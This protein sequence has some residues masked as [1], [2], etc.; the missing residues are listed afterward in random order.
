[1]RG[2][3]VVVLAVAATS[4]TSA[5]HAGPDKIAFPQ[6]FGTLYATVDRP[7]IK[8]YR[9]LY[10]SDAA[11]K[12]A[13]EGRPVPSG[14]VITMVQYRAQLDPQ[15][16]PIKDAN[17]RFVKGEVA[18][19]ALME[20]RT[21]WGGEYPPEL[22]NGEWEYAAF[23]PDKQFNQKANYKGCF[24][25]HKPHEKLDYV[26][27]LAK[28][29]GTFPTAAAQRKTGATDVNIAS[30]AFGPGKIAVQPGQA[31]SWTNTDD[32][33]HQIAVQGRK[34]GVLLKG[35]SEALKFDQ[36]GLFDYICSLHPTM[37]GQVEVKK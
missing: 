24:E 26:I 28:L 18:G 9:E 19:Y 36:E 30:F 8:Q 7:D 32:S 35:Q 17:G 23:T 3:P 34:T 4:L 33:P 12:A 14:T 13:R 1:M 37:K 16:N 15:G 20:K 21:G 27:S 2:S 6:Q 22:R 31:V 11:I 29:A 25:C 10:T 5:V